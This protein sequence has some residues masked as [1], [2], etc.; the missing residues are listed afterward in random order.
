[1]LS[2][3]EIRTLYEKRAR[4][5]DFSANFY[6]LAGFREDTY[7]KKAVALLDLKE[8]D[9]VV[10]IGCGTGLNFRHIQKCIGPNGRIIG[11]DLTA[12]MLSIARQRCERHSWRNVQLFEQDAASFTFP[13]KVDGVISSFALTLMPE[14]KAIIKHAHTALSTGRKLV[15]LDLKIPDWPKSLV[16]LAIALTRPFGVSR[17]I[18]QRHPWEHIQKIF[19]N[20]LMQEMYFGAVYMAVGLKK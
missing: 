6:Y 15:L 11:I 9:T 4:F 3:S 5:Y 10:E 13:D 1:M 12:D 7:R 20:L 8:G 2:I 16:N 14:Y 19:G 17:D 18:G